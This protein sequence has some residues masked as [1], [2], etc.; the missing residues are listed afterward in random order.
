MKIIIIL[1]FFVYQIILL[2]K[3]SLKIILNFTIFLKFIINIYNY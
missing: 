1:S 3:N 2:Y